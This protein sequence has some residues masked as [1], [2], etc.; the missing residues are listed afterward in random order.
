MH[1]QSQE[2]KCSLFYSSFTVTSH[3]HSGWIHLD[4]IF[5]LAVCFV[6]V[7]WPGG[8]VRGMH[9]LMQCSHRGRRNNS[10]DA[11]FISQSAEQ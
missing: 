7:D 8:D 1:F 2:Y 5:M 3:C 6:K 11:V 4:M 10:R 9:P